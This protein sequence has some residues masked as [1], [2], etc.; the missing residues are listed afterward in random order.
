M[1]KN[2]VGGVRAITVVAAAA[3]ARCTDFVQRTAVFSV[4]HSTRNSVSESVFARHHRVLSCGCGCC[5]CC[6]GEGGDSLG[7]A[8]ASD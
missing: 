5:R 8:G 1:A 6:H 7:A 4:T 3:A 2:D